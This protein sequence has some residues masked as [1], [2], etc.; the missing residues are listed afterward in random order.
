MKARELGG[1]VK[2]AVSG[3]S[4]DN[5]ASMG[6]AL[7]L[8]SLFS[9]GPLLVLVI[10]IAGLAIGHDRAQDLLMTQLSGLLGD[11]GAEGVKSLL[12][13]A[14]TDKGGIIATVVSGATLLL[15]ATTVFA[16]LQSDLNRIWKVD[17][18]K[19]SG[20]WSWLR[21]RLLSF[22][23]VVAVG[24]LLLVSLVVSAG[25]AFVGTRWF[26]GAELAAHALEFL[27]SIVVMT[28]LF[29]AIYKVLPST[30]MPWSDLWIG[31]LVTAVLFSI[32]KVL[33]G[34]YLGRAAYISQFG[35]AGTLVV[36]I[37]WVYYSA[38]VFFMGAEVTREYSLAHGSRRGQGAAAN[39]DFLPGEGHLVRRAEKIV[40]GQ[41]PVL[42][43]RRK[44]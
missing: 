17:T 5:C 15:G 33:I 30:R 6:A 11:A 28:L 26:G 14:S 40:K 1:V 41:D 42:L 27:A 38:Q 29:A 44:G 39:S 7:A 19:A 24:F 2:R 16:E 43:N 34:L 18:A 21:A 9:M 25:I 22:G 36:A 3:W 13:A 8:Y 32:G 12:S 35:A 23:I 10:A 4:A 31:A 20:I 37:F